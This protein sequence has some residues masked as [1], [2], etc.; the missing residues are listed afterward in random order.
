MLASLNIFE[1]IGLNIWNRPL[2]TMAKKYPDRGQG[3]GPMEEDL[4]R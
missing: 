3:E 2:I 1:E 4:L